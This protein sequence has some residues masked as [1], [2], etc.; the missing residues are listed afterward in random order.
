M[1]GSGGATAGEIRLLSR[2]VV[3]TL[4]TVAVVV[5]GGAA[6]VQA[7]AD[8]LSAVLGVVVGLF[9][10]CVVYVRYAPR[11]WLVLAD[12]IVVTALCLVQ[13]WLVRQEAL[14]DSTNWV[15]AVVTITAVGHQWFTSPG[16]GAALTGLLVAAHVGGVFLA[17][18]EILGSA[19]PLG[20]WVFGEAGLSRLLWF[21]LRSA[22]R[23]ADSAVAASAAAGREAAIAAARRADEREHLAVLHDTAAATLFAVGT[24]MVDGTESWLAGQASRDLEA[25]AAQR[26]QTDGDTDL[27]HMLTEVADQ[28]AITVRLRVARPLPVPDSAASAITAAVREALTN[29]VRHAGVDTAELTASRADGTVVVEVRDDG[30]GFDPHDVPAHRHGIAGSIAERMDRVGGRAV[31]TSAPA[32]GTSV[33]LE[34]SDE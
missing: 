12:A 29:V 20:L 3:V 28:A 4:R 1:E 22:G 11:R 15:L 7:P 2:P 21:Y 14:P 9:C 24:R 6:V 18:P 27:D 5:A 13:G 25:L 16:V 30:R 26:E 34:W 31:I 19:A 23:R 32:E 8:R 17:S 10:W 33:R